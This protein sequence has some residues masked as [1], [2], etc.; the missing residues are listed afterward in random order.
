VSEE[1][2]LFILNEHN[3]IDSE[4]GYKMSEKYDLIVVGAGP[5]GLMASIVT[6]EAGL[7]VL[8]I[9]RKKNVSKITRSCC[10]QWITE[11]MTHGESLSV[12]GNRVVFPKNDF[13]IEY[14]GEHIPLTHYIRFSPGGMKLLFS[15]E[16]DPVSVLFDKEALLKDL[17]GQADSQ[18]V[19]S[20]TGTLCTDA[21]EEE[22]R[23]S[24]KLRSKDGD[25]TEHGRYLILAD[26]VNSML[27]SKLGFHKERAL[28][29][30]MQTLSYLFENVECPHRA[31]MGFMGSGHL[32]GALGSIY[33]HP[34]PGFGEERTDVFEITI[35]SPVGDAIPL[36][37]KMHYFTQ[38]GHFAGWFQHAKRMHT[39]SAVLEFRTPLLTPAKG[40]ILVAGDAASFIETYVQ[41]AL[42]YGRGA[43]KAV[44]GKIEEGKDFSEYINHWRNTFGYNQPGEIEKATNAYGITMFSDEELDYIFSFTDSEK[45]TGYINEFYD[46]ER[47]RDVFFNHLGTMKK[48]KPD[49]AEKLE[50]HFN[51]QKSTIEDSLQM[52]SI[53]DSK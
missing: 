24:V 3:Y 43:A 27:G 44:I 45:H 46:F 17:L 36:E 1:K 25:K 37:D 30:Q 53:K 52:T 31:F 38:E 47:V 18:G 10:A 49:L 7:K 39:S 28:F 8:L 11:P 5:A 21:L 26:G 20:L 14:T 32:N 9:E 6:A 13:A 35:G 40:R 48:E 29:G 12:E 41:G 51:F 23:V 33:M 22:E 15:N 16:S 50:S 34:K 2:Y 19:K 42:I 4:K